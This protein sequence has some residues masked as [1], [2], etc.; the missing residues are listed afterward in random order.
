MSNVCDPR[1]RR[2]AHPRKTKAALAR[3]Q[4]KRDFTQTAEPSGRLA[5]LPSKRLRS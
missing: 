5:V 4:D 3:Y 1:S 2:T